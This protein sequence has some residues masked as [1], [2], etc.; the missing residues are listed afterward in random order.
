M[1]LLPE[2]FPH[3]SRTVAASLLTATAIAIPCGAWYYAG[4]QQ[5]EQE[6]VE[7]IRGVRDEA[8]RVGIMLAERLA[9]RLE[10]LRTAESR[11][12]FYHYQN[13]YHDP[14]GAS[15]GAAVTVS[16]LAQGAVDPLVTAH[17]QVD[18]EGA[19][20]LPTVNDEFPELGLDAENRYRHCAIQWELA[21]VA[22]FCHAGLL[23]GL[24]RADAGLVEGLRWSALSRKAWIQHRR[25]NAI[26][27]D[28][29]YGSGSGPEPEAPAP[30][31]DA[32][33]VRIGVGPLRWHS[34]PVG[35]TPA[36]V[37]LRPVRTPAGPWVQGFVVSAGSIR[38]ELPDT[39][40][41]VTLGPA[42]MAPSPSEI[43]V[44]IGGTP[45]ELRLDVG[46]A[47]DEVAVESSELRERF[48]RR[49]LLGASGAAGAGFL[50][51]L[52]VYQAERLARQRSRFAAAAAHELRTPLAG[53]RLHAEML[54]E[55][56]GDPERSRDYA[57]RIASEVERLGRV[58]TNVLGFS[59]LE[60]GA[61]RVEPTPGDLAVEVAGIVDRQRPILARAGLE[62]D[63][64]IEAGLPPVLFDRD[65]L[66]QILVNLLDNA[67]KHTRRPG[68]R[69][70]RVVLRDEA[71]G[72][73][74]AVEDDG[75]GISPA[76]RRGLFR[77]F[78]RGEV[79]PD[80][81]GIG[82]GLALVQTLAEAQGARVDCRES[83]AGGAAFLVR[84]R[85]APEALAGATVVP[86]SA[87]GR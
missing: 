43:G 7:K 86:L 37:A 34:L 17:F 85:R 30:E 52:L 22:Q 4:R 59:R 82:L 69:E 48:V 6:R 63:T 29:K 14:Q 2:G 20:G 13:L 32:E 87:S 65:A 39:E 41:P 44:A 3:P 49:F 57:R 19:L 68:S 75:P 77:P 9:G 51:V 71:E 36:L 70:A 33:S 24:D 15:E 35:D 47:L 1:K 83:P 72:V 27:G 38:S 40:L 25:A 23:E 67:D 5:V 53:M 55:G 76:V 50:V 74:L 66:E 12:P 28:L 21:E 42:L 18:E 78:S 62:V 84:F 26:F 11:R 73:V 58:V 81:E 54:S 79:E 10:L 45:W 64:E 46:P 56:L 61:F 31:T 16:P 8:E 60:R 80:I